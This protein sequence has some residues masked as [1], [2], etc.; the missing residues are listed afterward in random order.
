MNNRWEEPPM[1]RKGGQP[2]ATHH[3]PE[4]TPPAVM[5]MPSP[6]LRRSA[7]EMAV[8]EPATDLITATPWVERWND[9]TQVVR[10]KPIV[11]IERKPEP[12]VTP[13]GVVMVIITIV[14]TLVIVEILFGGVIN[15][16]MRERRH[17]GFA[18]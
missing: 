8:D 18:R 13:R 2:R 3:D 9:I 17:R 14:L 12:M 5:P 15:E 10:P 6:D 4:P 11:V 7:N 1:P 16:R